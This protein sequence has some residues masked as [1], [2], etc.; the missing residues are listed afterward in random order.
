MKKEY[1]I[2]NISAETTAE[3]IDE[4]L[5]FEKTAKQ[6]SIKAHLLRIVPAAAVIALVIGLVNIMT[7][8]PSTDVGIGEQGLSP[9]VPPIDENAGLTII[10]RIVEKYTFERLMADFP[11]GRPRQHML[12]YYTLKDI[13]DPRLT[14]ETRA[15]V[16]MRFPLID[17]GA[18]YIF[19]PNASEREIEMI[20]GYWND[21]IGWT[22]AEHTQ[23]LD[24]LFRI[25]DESLT[26]IPRI[27]AQSVFKD[28]IAKF[29]E[30]RAQQ[31]MLAYY[32]LRY[33]YSI[34]I[35]EITGWSVWSE[36]A[37]EL[38]EEQMALIGDRGIGMFYVFDAHASDREIAEMLSYWNEYSGWT[39]RDYFNML[40]A[41]GIMIDST[42]ATIIPVLTYDIGEKTEA[43]FGELW[44]VPRIVE[45]SIFE[46]FLTAVTD[47]RALAHLRA[48]YSIMDFS[49]PLWHDEEIAEL[50]ADFPFASRGAVYMLDPNASERELTQLLG[51]WNQYWDWALAPY[52][53]G[54]SVSGASWNIPE[55][56]QEAWAMAT[57]E[58]A[59]QERMQ[60][61]DELAADVLTD[62]PFNVERGAFYMLDPNMTQ[63]ELSQL[64]SFLSDTLID[65]EEVEAEHGVE[66]RPI[67]DCYFV[68][69]DV[70]SAF[71]RFILVMI[72]S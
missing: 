17:R 38:T 7:M 55:D 37:P 43:Q 44:S 46:N 9:G 4:M 59:A 27:I 35:P 71:A 32:S 5:Q 52:F 69:M 51:Y 8:L 15:E 21:Y 72:G 11:D 13:A 70:R 6:R 66:W 57:E 48:Y 50:F 18:F 63:N 28:L 23:M 54:G 20:L 56:R 25:S 22:D 47:D 40:E 61:I 36:P 30:G 41:Y 53:D 26:Y 29:P 58:R 3:L 42:M 16:F 39:D 33:F 60:D 10:P 1:F 12:A 14:D 45:Q 49:D 67:T 64:H 65:W 31:K 24:D 62:F 34:L 19:D 68:I 2:E